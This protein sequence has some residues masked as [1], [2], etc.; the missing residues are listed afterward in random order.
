[1]C[2]IIV[3]LQDIFLTYKYCYI[4]KILRYTETQL[5]SVHNECSTEKKNSDF[6]TKVYGIR[7]NRVTQIINSLNLSP[8]PDCY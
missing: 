2:K 6:T 4:L 7:M 1:M 8:H 5:G 3:Q